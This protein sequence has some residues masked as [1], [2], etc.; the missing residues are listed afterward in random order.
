MYI[1]MYMFPFY[2]LLLYIRKP[3]GLGL[4]YSHKQTDS[5]IMPYALNNFGL[6]FPSRVFLLYSL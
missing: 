6:E 5:P 1:C 3:L 2:Q 4:A